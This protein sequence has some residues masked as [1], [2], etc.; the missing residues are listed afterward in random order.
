M[1]KTKISEFSA[2]P[3]NNT[4]IDSINL[5]EGMAPSLVNDAIRELMAQLKDFQTGAVGDSFNG[6]V[7]STT[8]A[9]GAF[10]TLSASST[11]A[12]TGVATLTAQ[13]ILSSLTASR[14]VFTDASKGLV[15]NAITGTGNVVM[16]T[17][18]TLVTP[19]LGTPTSGTLTNA[20]GLPL[21]TGVTGTLP[22]LN[23]GTGQTTATAAFNALAPSQATNSG[24][25]LTTDGTNS[26]WATVSGSSG[27]VTSVA[28]TVPSILSITGSPIT[29]SGTLA[30]TYSGTALPIANGGTNSTATATAGGIGYGTGT[31]HAYTSAGT[32]GQ[33]LTS[34]GASA[35]TWATPSSGA[36]VLISTQTA[37]ASASLS[38]TGLSTYTRYMLILENIVPATS[39]A[40]TRVQIGTGATPTYVTSGY[41]CGSD[42][43]E[44]NFAGFLI[45]NGNFTVSNGGLNATITLMTPTAGYAGYT[46]TSAWFDGSGDTLARYAAGGG[47]NTSTSTVTAFRLIFDSGNI[48]S[49]KASL[50][51]ISS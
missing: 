21:S 30:I 7:G 35:P 6:P 12:V 36:M 9:A 38:W 15:S 22:I 46:F 43:F 31:A 51:G 50:Y 47:R 4:D 44:G 41:S 5:A 10:T 24:K 34:A 20:T 29:T 28:A 45:S 18:P 40:Q 37:S 27:T 13:P 8:A 32:S 14:A 39:N 48:T 1:A 17:S 42:A 3:A 33:V 19:I 49:G 25:Y 26:S 23:G 2:T 11:L 16:S